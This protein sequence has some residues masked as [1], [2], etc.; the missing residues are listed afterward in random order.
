MVHK[1]GTKLWESLPAEQ[2][3]AVML[4]LLQGVVLHKG[5]WLLHKGERLLATGLLLLWVLEKYY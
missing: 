3:V 5:V 4:L 1:A 2:P